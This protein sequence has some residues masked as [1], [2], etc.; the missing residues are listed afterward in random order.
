MK[1]AD[2]KIEMKVEFKGRSVDRFLLTVQDAVIQL[3]RSKSRI[4][5][6]FGLVQARVEK[7]PLDTRIYALGQM[8]LVCSD[9]KTFACPATKIWPLS[10]SASV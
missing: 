6:K 2:R 8:C 3:N 10:G 7:R 1:D 4:S 9:M 5:L